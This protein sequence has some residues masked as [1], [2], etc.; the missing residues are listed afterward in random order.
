MHNVNH[1]STKLQEN[2]LFW[3]VCEK[4]ILTNLAFYAAVILYESK[5]HWNYFQTVKSK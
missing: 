2:L 4:I 5:G 3:K 1:Y